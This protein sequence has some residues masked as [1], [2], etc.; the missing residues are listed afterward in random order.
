MMMISMI[1]TKASNCRLAQTAMMKTRRA[2]QLTNRMT[3][4]MHQ[5]FRKNMFLSVMTDGSHPQ[6]PRFVFAQLR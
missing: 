5:M 1:L 3:K 4:E 2:G 6:S